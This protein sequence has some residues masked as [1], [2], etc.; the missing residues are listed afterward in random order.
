MLAEELRTFLRVIRGEQPVSFGA[1]YDDAIQVQQWMDQLDTC[2][3]AA[4]RR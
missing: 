4:A 2:A 3:W 1:S